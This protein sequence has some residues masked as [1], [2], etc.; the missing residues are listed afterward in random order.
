MINTDSAFEAAILS[1]NS[2]EFVVSKSNINTEIKEMVCMKKRY[3]YI[4]NHNTSQHSM[5][6]NN[7][8]FT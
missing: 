5:A 4:T 7:L 8:T 2:W 3:G 1:L 6:N